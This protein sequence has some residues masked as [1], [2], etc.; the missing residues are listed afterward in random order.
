[1]G[2]TQAQRLAENI[3]DNDFKSTFKELDDHFKTYSELSAGQGQIRVQVSIR[4]NIKAYLQW[5][6][7]EICLARDQSITPFPVGQVT[8]LIRRYKTHEKFQ[9]DSKTFAKAAKPVHRLD[10]VG[11]LETDIL[12]LYQVHP[13]SRWNPIEVCLP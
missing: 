2:Q 7:D 5:T 13:W 3:F 12:E 8:D 1:M 6:R 10:Q 11:G 9:S 4:K